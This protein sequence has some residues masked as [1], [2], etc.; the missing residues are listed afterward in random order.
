M[1]AVRVRRLAVAFKSKV[2][3]SRQDETPGLP[4]LTPTAPS[5]RTARLLEVCVEL[6]DLCIECTGTIDPVAARLV[7]HAK[8]EVTLGVYGVTHDGAC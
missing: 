1:A 3:D 7:K 5:A 6:L 4:M 2:K 8:D